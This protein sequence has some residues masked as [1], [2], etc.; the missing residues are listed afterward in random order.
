M[1]TP[2]PGAIPMQRFTFDCK[3]IA[4]ISVKAET[5]A[6]ARRILAAVLECADTNFGAFPDGSP[7]LGEVSLTDGPLSDV[8]AYADDLEQ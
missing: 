1:T 3:L 7:V 2:A 6:D 4:A 5:V 8:L